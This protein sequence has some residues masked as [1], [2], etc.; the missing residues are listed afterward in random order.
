MHVEACVVRAPVPHAEVAVEASIA[1]EVSVAV[2][3]YNAVE[4]PIAAT[5][6]IGVEVR[7]EVQPRE[8]ATKVAVPARERRAQAG[9]QVIALR[10]VRRRQGVA[11]GLL[12]TVPLHTKIQSATGTMRRMDRIRIE[13][14]GTFKA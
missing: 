3:V 2:E 10:V 5:V 6:C 14:S 7:G 12:R 9:R 4:V 1:V 11:A 8:Q 13:S